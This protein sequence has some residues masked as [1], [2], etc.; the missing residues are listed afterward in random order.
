MD[1]FIADRP[2]LVIFQSNRANTIQQVY[3]S[4]RLLRQWGMICR[5]V[6]NSKQPASKHQFWPGYQQILGLIKKHECCT[7][8]INRHTRRCK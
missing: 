7:C 3:N 4:N 5:G 6:T 1:N 2:Q 8:Y